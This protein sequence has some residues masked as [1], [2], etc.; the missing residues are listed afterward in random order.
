MIHEIRGVFIKTNAIAILCFLM[1]L[2]AQARDFRISAVQES[3]VSLE[4]G[5]LDGLE[6]GMQGEI[7]YAITIAGQTKRIM[8]ATVTL[9][10]VEDHQSMGTLKD[11]T[12]SV[13]IGYYAS[14][15]P[16]FPGDMLTRLQARAVEAFN[17]KDFNLARQFYQKILEALPDDPFATQKVKECDIQAEKL[18][19]LQREIKKIPYYKQVIKTSMAVKNEESVKLV[20]AYVDK[21]LAVT[22]EDPDAL[23]YK[24][25]ASIGVV[26]PF[27]DMVL[28]P[29]SDTIIG[30][31]TGKTPFDNETPRQKVHVT[32]FYIDKYE[33][34]NEEYKRFCDAT[35]HRYPEYFVNGKFPEGKERRPVVMV[36]W[37]DAEAYA[38]WSGKRLLSEY[39]W[40]VAAAG[41]SARAWP[42]GD[43]W[44]PK[45]ANTHE[46]GTGASAD[47]GSYLGDV[48]AYGVYD[49]AGNVSEWTMDSY[50]L[51][52]GNASKGPEYNEQFKVMRGSSFLGSKDF[53][54]CRFRGR[55]PDTFRSMDMGF[56]CA[57]SPHP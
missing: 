42:W 11:Q 41:T 36:N 5:L 55:L 21:I 2:P 31:E 18:A 46:A 25:W 52:L 20:Q 3:H 8:P 26:A 1:C 10:K 53:A 50:R 17:G 12:G 57:L 38:R 49:M 14:L 15:V 28:I 22:P 30:S 27:K 47:V 56:R 51:Y 32:A 48:S 35:G 34:T 19:L 29:E 4:G 39:E 24:K 13:K 40:E 43:A 7:F 23:E 54:R 45:A 44:D 16:R 6:E 37:I 9:Y 33:V